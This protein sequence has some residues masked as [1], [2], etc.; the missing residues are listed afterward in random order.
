[1]FLVP[2]MNA[3]FRSTCMLEQPLSKCYKDFVLKGK[4][5]M[6]LCLSNIIIIESKMSMS[7]FPCTIPI[8]LQNMDIQLFC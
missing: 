7:C 6:N 4:I 8:I 2:V 1:M 3:W 5:L